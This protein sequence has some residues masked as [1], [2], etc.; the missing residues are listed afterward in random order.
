MP[1]IQ[2]GEAYFD[3][4][5]AIGQWRTLHLS[6]AS[7]ACP[8]V[9]TSAMTSSTRVYTVANDNDHV[10]G[11]RLRHPCDFFEPRRARDGSMTRVLTAAAHALL[12]TLKRRLYAHRM[13]V[14]DIRNRD[15]V[16][17]QLADGATV[18]AIA[19]DAG[20]SAPNRSYLARPSSSRPNR[21]RKDATDAQ[22]SDDAVSTV[23]LHHQGRGCASA[24][25]R[26]PPGAG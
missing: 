7:T 26:T 6:A 18:T 4:G 1:A 12:F 8:G 14:G 10:C 9:S 17:A 13:G 15:W 5:E 2:P 19:H 21:P 16:A 3:T 20:V 11:R 24:S 23:R 22:S 25:V